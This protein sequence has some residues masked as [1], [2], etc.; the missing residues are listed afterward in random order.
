MLTL[1]LW[2]CAGM[3]N[4]ADDSERD[5]PANA[6]PLSDTR[7][8]H[9]RLLPEGLQT[10]P[11]SVTVISS[12]EVALGFHRNLEDLETVVPG[13]IVDPLAGA[14]QGAVIAIRGIGSGELAPGFE[15]AVPIII[16]GVSRSTH[17]GRMN[18]LFD[19]EQVEVARGPQGSTS[20]PAA[21]GGTI[22]VRRSRPAGELDGSV[23]LASGTFDR[24]VFEGILHAP[25]VAGFSSKI[26]ARWIA[27]GGDYLR[28][29]FMPRAENDEN[30]LFVSASVLYEAGDNLQLQYTADIDSDKS[31]A[32]GLLNISASNTPD[33]TGDLLCETLGR[34]AAGDTSLLTPETG[35]YGRTLQNFSNA[36]ELDS[37]THTLR[38]S[39]QLPRFE[40]LSITALHHADSM[41]NQDVDGTAIDFYSTIRATDHDQVSQELRLTGTDQDRETDLVLGAYFVDKNY[42]MQ[43]TERFVMNHLAQAGLVTL[44]TPGTAGDLT[45]SA[46]ENSRKLAVYGHVTRRLSDKWQGDLG[47]RWHSV[48]RTLDLVQG[49]LASTTP[50]GGTRLQPGLHL[51]GRLDFTNVLA[52]ASL[53]YQVDDAAIVYLRLSQGHRSGGFD[54][55]ARTL[56]A[57]A[58]YGNEGSSSHEIGLKSAWRDD[59]L[60]INLVSWRSE[61]ED[62]AVVIPDPIGS[63]IEQVRRN[64]AAVK[65]RGVDLEATWTPVDALRVQ[66]TLSHQKAHFRKYAADDPENPGT[67]FDL[68]SRRPAWSPPD[69]AALTASYTWPYAAGRFTAFARYKYYSDYQNNPALALSKVFNTTTID[70]ALAFQYEQWNFRLFSNN[71]LDKR[72]PLNVNRVFATNFVPLDLPVLPLA[73]GT[74]LP[75]PTGLLTNMHYNL[76]KHTGLEISW[77]PARSSR[78]GR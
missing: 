28:N 3:A 37:E 55:A 75:Q 23:K 74:S 58:P 62:Q 69:S 8:T 26:A 72:F 27:G 61:I 63:R 30:S 39:W 31:D 52:S 11:V 48:E 40:L 14:P 57:F 66:M 38:A 49:T 51:T 78:T 25:K 18:V 77:R 29:S 21:L 4:A 68:S 64:A 50:A 45:T 76:P 13:L 41:V 70:V 17:A 47:L 15:P 46:D 44:P 6:Q 10:T 42:T 9:V 33:A 24:R 1:L 53:R 60:K 32:P 36:A 16:D 34:C 73:P 59:T 22:S 43:L 5:T 54:A 19:F 20:G 12:D 2:T 67:P 35:T 71:L 56:A 7:I 65:I